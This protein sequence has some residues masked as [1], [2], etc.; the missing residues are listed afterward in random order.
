MVAS[1]IGISVAVSK[2]APDF[3][4]PTIAASGDYG[5]ATSACG[6]V[7]LIPADAGIGEASAS[8]F[9]TCSQRS[10]LIWSSA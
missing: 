9:A 10:G 1:C 7:A 6:P 3:G 2:S 5:F 8:R 4:E